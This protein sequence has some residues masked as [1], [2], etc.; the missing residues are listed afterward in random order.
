[1]TGPDWYDKKTAAAMLG[2]SEKTVDRMAIRGEIQREIRSTPGQGTRPYFKPADV[3]K[4]ATQQPLKV[5]KSDKPPQAQDMVRA[6]L[7]A[8][9]E[10]PAARNGDLPL[11]ELRHK[12]YLSTAEAVRYSGLSR[13]QLSDLVRLLRLTR[14][15][16]GRHKYRRA[17]LE[18]L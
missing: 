10:A 13:A 17:D 12:V 16:T 15:G 7:A 8:I 9:R 2:V 18:A 6:L 3:S 5:V 14:Y 4:L 1:M 11:S